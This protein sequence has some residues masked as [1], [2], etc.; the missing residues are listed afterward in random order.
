MNIEL[1]KWQWSDLD[2]LEKS[3]IGAFSGKIGN[4]ENYLPSNEFVA[5][6]T[7][8]FPFLS[9]EDVIKSAGWFGRRGLCNMIVCQLGNL[10]TSKKKELG[11]ALGRLAGGSESVVSLAEQTVGRLQKDSSVY[12]AIPSLQVLSE[13]AVER[14]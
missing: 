14:R 3:V 4:E 12:D 8:S 6:T 5:A 10:E 11:T 1:A 13:L 7:E 2:P 9:E